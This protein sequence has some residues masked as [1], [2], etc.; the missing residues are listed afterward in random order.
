MALQ[1]QVI[2]VP[3][4]RG[5]DQKSD[6]RWVE[7]GAQTS[8]LN[9]RWTKSGS[10]RKRYGSIAV[11]KV[12][13]GGGTLNAGA[14]VESYRGAPIVS[15][16]SNLYSYSAQKSALVWNDEL[17]ECVATRTGITQATTGIASCDVAITNGYVCY[18]YRAKDVS[19]TAKNYATIIDVSTGAQIN[20]NYVLDGGT[21]HT[22]LRVVAGGTKFYAVWQ[23][24]SGHLV[25][26]DFDTAGPFLWSVALTLVSDVSSSALDGAWD[27]AP[28][29]GS[30]NQVALAYQ[31]NDTPTNLVNVIL[32]NSSLA[33]IASNNFAIASGILP[34][35][36]I[37][38]KGTSGETL[39]V[40]YTTG[41][42][43]FTSFV[44]CVG[45]NPST[46]AVMVADTLL[47]SQGYGVS[48]IGA[49]RVNATTCA[50]VASASGGDTSWRQINSAAATV[51]PQRTQP[52]YSLWSRPTAITTANGTA[53]MCMM[54]SAAGIGVA[55]Q[56]YQLVDLLV[57]DT[58]SDGARGRPVATVGARIAADNTFGVGM[59]R[60]AQNDGQYFV[61]VSIQ[62]SSARVGLYQAVLDFVTPA[63]HQA[64][65][66][67]ESLYLSG[68]IPTVFDGVQVAE[69]G[70][71]RDPDSVGVLVSTGGSVD[72]GTHQYAIVFRWFNARGEMQ[73]SSPHFTANV[74]TTS[75]NQTVTINAVP[76]TLT[77]K[78]DAANG[79]TPAV[80]FDVYR[81][82]IQD[83]ATFWQVALDSQ[84]VPNDPRTS[85]TI[86]ITDTISDATLISNAFGILYTLGGVLADQCPPSLTCLCTHKS[87]LFG[88]GDDG[89]T[90]WFTKQYVP[91]FTP[92]FNDQ[93][94]LSV[95]E[96]GGVIT[97][98]ASLDDH[99]V[100][101][102]QDRIFSLYGSG[103]DSTGNQSDFSDFVR[104]GSP[105]GCTQSRSVV[106][107]AEGVYFLSQQ[108][109]YLLTRGGEA[110]YI[111]KP[112]E[113]TVA[114][115]PVCTAADL[116]PGGGEIRWALSPA[117]NPSSHGIVVVYDYVQGSWSV[118]NYFD[119]DTG[120]AAAL[121]AGARTAGGTWAWLGA[122]GHLYVENGSTFLDGG[123]QW[124]PLQVE[125]AW[126]KAGGIEGWGRFWR[127]TFSMEQATPF[128]I[129]ADIATGY[130]DS[131]T[132]SS[133]FSDATIE[134]WTTAKP[135]AVVMIGDQRSEAVRFRFT[136]AAPVTDFVGT[137]E[138]PRLLGCNVEVGIKPGSRGTRIPAAQRA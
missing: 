71:L 48:N 27:I 23:D 11:S 42:V 124:V 90:L 31:R 74:A 100:I 129:T 80:T 16:G 13:V 88:V 119:A 54:F 123:T 47:W 66:L 115:N 37:A 116:V 92:G 107:G 61:P 68:G 138:G 83:P 84:E 89:L 104:V 24:A 6:P 94:T 125:T 64:V 128:Q 21:M 36:G 109:L 120:N 39:W 12:S 25:V 70:F 26:S 9:G 8:V 132:Q 121:V 67:G 38:L 87:R 59:P 103:P 105:V 60:I 44:R 134:G 95:P 2:D 22:G 33:S 15:D 10:L 34:V 106:V 112:V 102:K 79:W 51:G 18:V 53:I 62:Q 108:G 117:N 96:D 40:A 82:S 127:L 55:G 81:N 122:E 77:T 49:E 135:V 91:G 75:G 45:L 41:D 65:E 19:G 14:A 110:V 57:A 130:N 126:I 7:V 35:F 99:L 46:L 113:D 136:D 29:D 3:F 69:H 20:A 17:P 118:D 30:A 63:R 43:G 1:K 137:G 86:A 50:V 85:G 32:F 101:F 4:A 133:S 52:G 111:G 78:Q 131:Y 72:V 98:L 28:V 114:A 97:G 58:A 76:Y 73:R 93:L 56:T 5:V